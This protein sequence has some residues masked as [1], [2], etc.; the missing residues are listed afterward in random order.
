MKRAARERAGEHGRQLQVLA[1]QNDT[2][3]CQMY[4]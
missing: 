3:T 4:V 2:N 1:V